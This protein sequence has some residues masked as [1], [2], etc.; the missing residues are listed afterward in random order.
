MN[1][2]KGL[3]I[4]ITLLI[5]LCGCLLVYNVIQIAVPILVTQE[6]KKET[7][8]EIEEFLANLGKIED[9]KPDEPAGTSGK[10]EDEKKEEKKPLDVLTPSGLTASDISGSIIGILE[11]DTLGIQ[12]PVALGTSEAILQRYAGMFEEYDTEPGKEGLIAIA[13]HSTRYANNGYTC[14]FC[15]F[16]D[17]VNAQIGDIVKLTWKDGNTY[18]YAVYDIKHNVD[19][20]DFS[21]FQRV[22]GKEILLL[23]TCTNGVHGTRSYIHA[24]RVS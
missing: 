24:Q 17:L 13:S 8:K 18:Y 15:Y 7:D 20:E 11:V 16:Q 12:A 14:S 4:L 2:K 19:A 23:Q 3:N 21:A 9:K 5:L 22:P 6:E 1:K 10:S